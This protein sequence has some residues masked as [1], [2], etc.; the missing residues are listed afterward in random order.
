MELLR[1]GRNF[2]VRVRT[3]RRRRG[4]RRPERDAPDPHLPDL[5]QPGRPVLRGQGRP[6]ARAAALGTLPPRRQ[7]QV[8]GAGPLGLRGG[9]RVRRSSTCSASSPG[10]SIGD[11]LGGVR[12]REIAVYRASGNRGNTPEAEVEYLKKLVAETRRQGAEVPPRRPDEQERRLAA[13]PDRAAHPAGPRGVR[14]GDDPLRRLEQLLRRRARRS[15]SA[16]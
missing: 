7:L 13:R 1:N 5:P 12:R 15:R 10:K 9:R 8:P 4:D 3:D 16:G 2:L 14:P 11:L 6:P